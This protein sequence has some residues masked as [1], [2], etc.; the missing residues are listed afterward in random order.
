ME[1]RAISRS[2]VKGAA[3]TLGSLGFVA[4]SAWMMTLGETT[5]RGLPTEVIGLVGIVFFGACLG[6]GV[7]M[8][9]DRR[10]GFVLRED[11]FE[12]YSSGV[13]VGFVP[14]GDIREI[15]VLRIS[16]QRFI[17]VRVNNPEV[18]ARRGTAIQRMA[19]RANMKLC[20]TPV[21]ISSNTLR[22]SFDELVRLLEEGV[23]RVLEEGVRRAA[24]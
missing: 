19:H 5:R 8:V 11:G 4:L 9:F 16:G 20:G 6:F 1:T 3:L 17:A 13:A 23:G 7:R 21:T 14:W 22:I 24:R 2:R 10:P 18:Y 15:A 12:D